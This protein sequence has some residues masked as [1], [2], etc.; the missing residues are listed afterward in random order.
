MITQL[1]GVNPIDVWKVIYGV[2]TVRVRCVYGETTAKLRCVRDLPPHGNTNSLRV[3]CLPACRRLDGPSPNHSIEH[4][5]TK[6]MKALL[7][8]EKGA[9]K[10]LGLSWERA[11]S[12]TLTVCLSGTEAPVHLVDKPKGLAH[13]GASGKADIA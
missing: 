6:G 5:E 11:N 4:K 2:Y 10:L 1:T 12:R 8:Q 3:P 9:G 7:H 13:G